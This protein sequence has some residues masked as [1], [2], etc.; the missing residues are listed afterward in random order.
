MTCHILCE[1]FSVSGIVVTCHILCELFSVG[2]RYCCDM[3][4]SV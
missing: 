1:L 3:S 4:H 2:L